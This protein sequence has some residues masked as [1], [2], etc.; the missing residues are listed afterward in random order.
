MQVFA[1]APVNGV[2]EIY[3][4]FKLIPLPGINQLLFATQILEYH[5]VQLA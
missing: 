2:V 1:A 4:Q 5:L 3:I